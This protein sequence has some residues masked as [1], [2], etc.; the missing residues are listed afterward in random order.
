MRRNRWK[1]AAGLVALLLWHTAQALNPTIRLEDLNRASWSEKD[2]VPSN[3]QCMAQTRDGWLWLG[4][5][6]GLYRFD[7]VSFERYPLKRSRIFSL[8]ASD[9]GDLL[10]SYEL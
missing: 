4:T 1:L 6:D 2:G 5:S 10:I 8:R 3:I 9:N 7:G